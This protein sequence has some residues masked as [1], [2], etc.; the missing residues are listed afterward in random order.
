L[1]I[2]SGSSSCSPS[3][4]ASE[5]L[6]STVRIFASSADKPYAQPGE[7]VTVRVLAY[8]GR[9]VVARAADTMAVTWLPIVCDDPA[10]DA[11]YNCFRPSAGADAGPG[12]PAPSGLEAGL[13]P[14]DAMAGDALGGDAGDAS[15]GEADAAEG[16][17]LAPSDGAPA[18]D[19]GAAQTEAGTGDGSTASDAAGQACDPA[20]TLGDGGCGC[21]DTPLDPTLAVPVVS[22]QTFRVPLDSVAAHATTPGAGVPYGLTILFNVACAGTVRA[23]PID[24]A[25]QNPQTVPIG[26]FGSQGQQQGADGYVFGFTR[27]YSYEPDAGPDG[28]PITNQNP[29]VTGVDTAADGPPPLCLRGSAPAYTTSTLVATLCAAD[30]GPCPSVRLGPVVPPSSQETDP[31]THAR[32][33][34]WADYYSTLGSLSHEAKLL[35]DPVAGSVGGLSTTDNEFQ[36]PVVGPGDPHDGYIFI[37]VHDDRGGATWVTVPVHLQ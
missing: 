7:S 2:A 5:D 22:E 32:E 26:C 17:G 4:F 19:A 15:P 30:G 34:V 8:D 10:S 27:I 3:G 29:E 36:P 24:P 21:V 18:I 13:P 11:Y 31:Q 14:N 25:N 1:A 35:Y 33:V 20:A 23:V 16:G 28:G 9:P 37:V 12:G 6:V